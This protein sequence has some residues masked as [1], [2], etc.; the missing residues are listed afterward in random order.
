MYDSFRSPQRTF[1]GSAGTSMPQ[2]S[3]RAD[4]ISIGSRT[5]ISSP[6]STRPGTR[7]CIRRFGSAESERAEQ[8]RVWYDG[9][10]TDQPTQLGRRI[11]KC[12]R[13]LRVEAEHERSIRSPYSTVRA[14]IAVDRPQSQQATC[15]VELKVFST[16][17]TRPSSIKDAIRTTLKR[18]A[19]FAGFLTRQ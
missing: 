18:H 4:P 13:I 6:S 16:E 2:S 15:I 19:Q 5:R 14:D 1:I 17:G 9:G 12:L 11:A 10:V 7:L 8:A 3:S